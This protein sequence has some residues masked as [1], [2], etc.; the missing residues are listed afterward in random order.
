M[1]YLPKPFQ[2]LDDLFDGL[3]SDKEVEHSYE[4][5]LVKK[6]ITSLNYVENSIHARDSGEGNYPTAADLVELRS[7]FA[8]LEEMMERHKG[9]F[10]E[11]RGEV[12]TK[13]FGI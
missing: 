7:A 2:D 3:S 5:A 4:A 9:D 6:A 12:N 13:N 11:K 8:L 1:S 10:H